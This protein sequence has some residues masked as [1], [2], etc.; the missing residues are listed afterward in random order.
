M[1]KKIV[2]KVSAIT[3][4]SFSTKKLFVFVHEKYSAVAD[5][6]KKLDDIS[7]IPTPLLISRKHGDISRNILPSMLSRRT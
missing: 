4:S 2:E 7:E 6:S 1:I 3:Y 5:I